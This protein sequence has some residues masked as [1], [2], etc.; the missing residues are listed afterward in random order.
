MPI[1][2]ERRRFGRAK[3]PSTK[4][5]TAVPTK[6]E[7]EPKD[8]VQES[9]QGL[10]EMLLLQR[11]ERAGYREEVE[12]RVEAR[13]LIA[14]RARKE[15]N[16]KYERLQQAFERMNRWEDGEKVE[17]AREESKGTEG[18]IS[19]SYLC[20]DSMQCADRQNRPR[21]VSSGGRGVAKISSTAR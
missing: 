10:Q 3:T 7:L 5:Q 17:A 14:Q 13:E 1:D 11:D 21:R 6:D 2:D 9:L 19:L 4:L 15:R 18:T 12:K 8:E 20:R 16:E